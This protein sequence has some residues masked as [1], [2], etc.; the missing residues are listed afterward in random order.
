MNYGEQL[1]IWQAADWPAWRYDL[2]K[3]AEPLAEVSR[4]QGVLMGRLADVGTALR[5]Q[6]SLAALTDDVVKTNEI[7]GEQLN[8]ESVRSSIARRLGVDMGALAPMDRH[9]E[10][11]VD[12]VLDASGRC[13]SPLTPERLFGWHASLFPTGFSGLTRIRVGAW[14]DDATGP[15]QVISGQ[16]LRQRVHFEAPPA[17]QLP[18]EAKRFFTWVNAVTP[19]PALI[20]AGLGHLW[21]VTLHPFEDGNGRIARAVGDLLLARAEGSSQRFYSLSAQIQRER[22]D[23]YNVLERTQK[24][25]LDVTEWLLWFLGALQRAVNSTQLSL[26]AVLVKTKFWRRWSAT[27][28]NQR[29]IKLLNRMLDGWDG[30]LTSSKWATLA[31]CSPDTALRDI[32]ELIALGTLCKLPSGGRSTAYNIVH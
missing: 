19:E 18:V 23:Y 27:P 21:L 22:K 25:T 26:D 14:R 15:M 5:D 16:G 1:Y 28:M 32:N 10:G 8:V 31:K 4:A 3:L 6:A 20:K 2:A 30:K 13:A 9:V 11:V 24:G 12:M 29:Q 17:A 7:E